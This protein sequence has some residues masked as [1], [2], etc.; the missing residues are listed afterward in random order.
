MIV[1]LSHPVARRDQF[2]CEKKSAT[3][4]NIIRA[5]IPQTMGANCAVM[6]STICRNLLHYWRS[7]DGAEAFEPAFS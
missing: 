2:S 3:P 6:S 4:E 1:V 5:T 7:K